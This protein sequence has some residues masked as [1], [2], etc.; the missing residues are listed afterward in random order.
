MISISL[1]IV[2]ALKSF[3]KQ[4]KHYFLK[5]L[6]GCWIA[7]LFM[8]LAAYVTSITMDKGSLPYVTSTGEGLLIVMVI[9]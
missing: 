5:C 8:V 7:P 9:P 1:Q 3:G 6:A 4:D 2:N